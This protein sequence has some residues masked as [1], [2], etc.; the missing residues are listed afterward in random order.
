MALFDMLKPQWRHSDPAVRKTAV[1]KLT[2]QAALA[3]VAKSD[4]DPELREL[5]AWRLT[6]QKALAAMA[7]NDTNSQV[8]E[9]AVWHLTDR[10]VLYE[11]AKTESDANVRAAVGS[12]LAELD[13]PTLAEIEK[14]PG[15]RVSLFGFHSERTL[16]H[17]AYFI[18]RQSTVR[19]SLRK[20]KQYGDLYLACF[21]GIPGGDYNNYNKVW[22]L[23]DAFGKRE[24]Y[25]TE[26]MDYYVADME[27]DST[28]LR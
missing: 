12:R 2:S 21:S 17:A 15:V 26:K 11:L 7:R 3:K 4:I 13:G 9:A 23:I 24:A 25:Y 20:E 28:E 27:R 6:D 1:A 5:A 22:E 14:L 19:V 8:R 16:R 18:K 10:T